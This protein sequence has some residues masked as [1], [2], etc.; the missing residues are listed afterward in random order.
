MPDELTI[1]GMSF[2]PQPMI[3]VSP[4]RS[5]RQISK[6]LGPTLWRG[7]YQSSR[8]RPDKAGIA[9][10][11][12]DTLLSIE[13]FYGYDKLRQYPLA[14]SNGW[15]GLLV[16]GSPFSGAG[17][18][19]SVNANNKE[20][21]IDHLPIGFVLSPGD[22]LAYD[23]ATSLRALHRCSA[24][25]TA[26]GSGQSTVEVRP[27]IRPGFTAG[28]AIQFYRAAARMIILP[29]SYQE[30]IVARVFTTISFDAIQSL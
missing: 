9:R 26:N 17:Q 5:G 16:S 20:M 7:H 8:M 15:G 13:E 1:V 29:G 24:A 10:A 2:P 18:L 11:W 28:A 27:H 4:L 30:D 23:Y 12:Y 14:Y 6:D 3:E 21:T 22:Y 19:V 25:A